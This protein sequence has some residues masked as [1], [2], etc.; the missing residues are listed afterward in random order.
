MITL[1]NQRRGWVKKEHGW[2]RVRKRRKKLGLT[3]EEMANRLHMS[4]SGYHYIETGKRRMTIE[5]AKEISDI[6]QSHPAELFP[7]YFSQL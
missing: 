3:Q 4:T 5:R 2:T 7:E 1:S 6:L